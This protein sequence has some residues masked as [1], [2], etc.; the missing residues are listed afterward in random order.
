MRERSSLSAELTH[1]KEN[2][3]S[4]KAQMS[5]DA[6][7]SNAVKDIENQLGSTKAMLD[8]KTEEL[9]KYRDDLNKRL[10]GSSAKRI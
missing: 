9:E 3:G 1:I 5:S 6:Q 2:F 8:A 7:N 4:M 10:G